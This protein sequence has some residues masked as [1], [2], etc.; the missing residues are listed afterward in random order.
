M[1]MP[2]ILFQ[3]RVTYVADKSQEE[4]IRKVEYLLTQGWEVDG[5][6][7]FQ[8]GLHRQSLIK[9]IETLNDFLDDRIPTL[10]VT[11]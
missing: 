6:S 2:E 5:D 7:R 3:T 11:V 1:E 4:L 10:E 9:K 8:F